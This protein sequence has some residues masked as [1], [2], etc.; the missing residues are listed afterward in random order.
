MDALGQELLHRHH[1]RAPVQSASG[2]DAKADYR[3]RKHN[4]QHDE[5]A[6]L[7]EIDD[8]RRPIREMNERQR[9]AECRQCSPRDRHQMVLAAGARDDAVDF[10]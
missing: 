8:G 9:H 10:P 4:G 3:E 7:D 5:Y 6:K 2:H 1:V